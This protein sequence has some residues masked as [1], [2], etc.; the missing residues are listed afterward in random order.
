MTKDDTSRVAIGRRSAGARQMYQVLAND[1]DEPLGRVEQP[2]LR[3]GAGAPAHED[4]V[5][6]RRVRAVN[7]YRAA[8]FCRARQRCRAHQ[9]GVQN[10]N[11]DCAVGIELV[12]M[13]GE[14]QRRTR[15]QGAR[16]A[17]IDGGQPLG[18][19]L[20]APRS[21]VTLPVNSCSDRV[22]GRSKP[23]ASL[24]ARRRSQT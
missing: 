22:D 1:L 16:H 10:R 5:D 23:S 13:V 24:P 12:V 20:Q 3:R 7:M 2:A 9:T 14:C 19:M 8:H 21:C 17:R 6:D 11:T 4:G 18:E 15:L